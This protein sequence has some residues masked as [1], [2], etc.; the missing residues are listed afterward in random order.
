VSE[1]KRVPRDLSALRTA[2][3]RCDP[4]VFGMSIYSSFL[5]DTVSNTGIV[6]I[7]AV[8]ERMEGGHAVLC[9]G[10]GDGY[11]LCQNSWGSSWGDSGYFRIPVEY[12]ENP[13]L[14]DDFWTVTNICE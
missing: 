8:S 2:L 10:Y 7:P 1:Y 5:T 14:S 11:F 13:D 12:V 4:V 3:C 6:P 9:I